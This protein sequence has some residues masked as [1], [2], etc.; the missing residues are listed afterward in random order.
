MTKDVTYW[1]TRRAIERGSA[2]R[3]LN[4][5]VEATTLNERSMGRLLPQDRFLRDNV[6]PEDIVVVSVGGNDIAMAPAPCTICNILCLVCCVPS[7]C[8]EKG[9]GCC[10]PVCPLPCDDPCCGCC[11]SCASTL[12]AC[13]PCAGYFLHVFKVRLEKYV[14]AIVGKRKPR[15]VLISMIYYPDEVSRGSWADTALSA[16]GYNSPSGAAKLQLLIRRIFEMAVSQVTVPGTEVVPLPLFEA[17]DGKDPRDYEQRVEPSAAGG[18]K[19]ADLIL[20]YALGDTGAR[21]GREGGGGGGGG[22]G[23]VGGTG[24]GGGCG[25]GGGGENAKRM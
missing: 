25:G 24:C 21:G 17:L 22:G 12:G 10:A 6:G 23:G 16:L 11:C 14:R 15:K 3:G 4:T 20:D 1:V 19:M 13:P 18:A 7:C 5:A 9:F 8:V 2:F